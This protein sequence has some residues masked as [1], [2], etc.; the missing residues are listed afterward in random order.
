MAARVRTRERLVLALGALVA[1]AIVL[2]AVWLGMTPGPRA[3]P[4]PTHR[5]QARS[6]P[7]ARGDPGPDAAAPDPTRAPARAGEERR[8]VAA[9]GSPLPSAPH[10]T[11][12]VHGSPDRPLPGAEVAVFLAPTAAAGELVGRLQADAEGRCSLQVPGLAGV[13]PFELESLA[14]LV[15]VRHP[16]WRP[17]E[18]RLR[19]AQLYE[20]GFELRAVLHPGGALIGRVVGSSGQ[21]VAGASVTLLAPREPPEDDLTMLAR[22]SSAADGTFQAG[23]P[24]RSG[25]AVV[26]A[27]HSGHGAARRELSLPGAT[28]VE[29]GD[30][31]LAPAGMLEGRVVFPDGSPA[32]RAQVL[33]TALETRRFERALP[34]ATAIPGGRVEAD[35]SGR[36][37]FALLQDGLYRLDVGNPY[38]VDRT[39]AERPL[40]TFRTPAR[41]LLIETDHVALCVRVVDRAGRALDGVGVEAR[42]VRPESDTPEGEAAGSLRL[43]DRSLA[44]TAGDPPVA[45]LSADPGDRV[46]LR[47]EPATC[48]PAQ[49]LVRVGAV[50]GEQQITLEVFSRSQAV[51]L[52]PRVVDA[53]GAP[54]R[55]YAV[56]LFDPYTRLAL[57]T[58]LEPDADGVLPAIAPGP[59]LLQARSPR[60]PARTDGPLPV[61]LGAIVELRPGATQ[62]IELR[63]E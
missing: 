58:G 45:V 33:A 15:R 43:L 30:L 49:T 13:H 42:R 37:R 28:A 18:W 22:T 17:H 51:R 5:P 54:T 32:R 3:D 27:A 16:G 34:D 29:L 55:D 36:F 61:G 35:D 26:L 62:G 14:L 23:Y 19:P 60:A 38:T 24:T 25:P 1:G 8:D 2:V 40:R 56:D 46:V 47:A 9:G 57:R 12:L 31:R 6:A 59:A 50:P 63:L 52:R 48:Y 41:D 7:E 44:R 21:P 39:F 53:S 20:P 4:T 10:L 11:V